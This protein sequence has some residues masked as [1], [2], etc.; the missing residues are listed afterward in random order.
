MP[1]VIG[2]KLDF[3]GRTAIVTGGSQG[4]G[5][6]VAERLLASGANVS[7]WAVNAGR[8]AQAA[9]ALEGGNRIQ[10]L[11]ADIG[12]LS[13]IEAAT[14]AVID[15]YGQIDVLINNAGVAGPNVKMWEFPADVFAQMM[16]VNLLGTFY[17]CRTV[18]PHMI[19]RNYGRIVTV[20]SIAGKE[21]NPNDGAYST[22]K[23]A[24]ICL[25]KSLAKELAGYDI[26]VNCVTPSLTQTTLSMTLSEQQRKYILSKVPR[27]R[28][29]KIA[30]AAS[31]ICWAASEE[32]SFTTGATFDLSGGRAT[33]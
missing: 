6:G 28:M 21:G 20:S 30:E 25:T 17:C 31:M 3:T 9:K 23:A 12:N 5:L 22:S 32:N 18:V 11:E 8:L 7:I 27:G 33:Y 29:L 16:H 4:I 2:N 1:S 19:A 10:T 26:S 24:Q 14:K 15:R 13:A